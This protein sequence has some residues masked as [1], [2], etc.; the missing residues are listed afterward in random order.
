MGHAGVALSLD[1]ELQYNPRDPYAAVVVFDTTR[2][3]IRWSFGRDLLI[4]GLHEAAGEGDVHVWPSLDEAYQEI[5]VI[6]L[7][8][9]DGCALLQARL[10]DVARFVDRTTVLVAPGTESDH[11]DV[12]SAITAIFSEAA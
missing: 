3:P 2:G 5:L 4:A 10:D 11:L 6:E 1:V 7:T 9:G 12:D 8:S